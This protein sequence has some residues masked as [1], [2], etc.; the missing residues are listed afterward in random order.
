MSKACRTLSVY[1]KEKINL[2]FLL[3]E[4]CKDPLKLASQKLTSTFN[5]ILIMFVQTIHRLQ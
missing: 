5:I 2:Y 4:N 3:C 1:R